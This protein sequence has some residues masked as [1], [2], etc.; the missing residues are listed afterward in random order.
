MACSCR[1]VLQRRR[2]TKLCTVVEEY[3]RHRRALRSSHLRVVLA[4]ASNQRHFLNRDRSARTPLPW[5]TPPPVG[6]TRGHP[7]NLGVARACKFRQ[8]LILI[9]PEWHGKQLPDNIFF[10]RKDLAPV[11]P[12]WQRLTAP[13]RPS[14]EGYNLGAGK[15]EGRRWDRNLTQPEK[16]AESAVFHTRPGRSEP[17][18]SPPP[19]SR[20]GRGY[21]LRPVDGE[22]ATGRTLPSETLIS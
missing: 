15:R 10:P 1:R 18:G 11:V 7:L 14:R 3:A 20:R 21:P 4:S 16:P 6:H 12:S 2:R 9:P 19:G 8:G 13:I 5:V 22:P 17:A